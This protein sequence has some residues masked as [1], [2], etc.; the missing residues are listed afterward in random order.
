MKNWT[1]NQIKLLREQYGKLPVVALCLL[2]GKSA[3]AVRI[4]AHRMGL[5]SNL[6]HKIELPVNTIINFNARGMPRTKI[7]RLVGCSYSGV[8]YALKNHYIGRDRE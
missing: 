7:S 5:K 4:K 6:K 1:Y 8:R 2:I 3:P